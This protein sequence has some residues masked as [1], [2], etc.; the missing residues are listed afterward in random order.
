MDGLWAVSK[1][2][3]MF[4]FSAVS[5]VLL[6]RSNESHSCLGM[7]CASVYM[8]GWGVECHNTM[9]STVFVCSGCMCAPHSLLIGKNL[10]G[11]VQTELCPSRAQWLAILLL[12]LPSL[13]IVYGEKLNCTVQ[14]YTTSKHLLIIISGSSSIVIITV[15]VIIIIIA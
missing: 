7:I 6:M 4:F 13:I 5:A 3:H 11:M 8:A 2:K 15:S 1:D 9:D 12:A 14:L 10:S